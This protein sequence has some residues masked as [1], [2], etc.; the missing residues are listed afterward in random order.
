MHGGIPGGLTRSEGLRHDLG[1]W[2]D[3][4]GPGI[5]LIGGDTG[6]S[7]VIHHDPST[8]S[9]WTV[10]SDTTDGAWPVVRHVE[11]VLDA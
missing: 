11:T 4:A 6:V 8:N 10:V 9:T 3:A 2:L 5:R 1:F 7:C